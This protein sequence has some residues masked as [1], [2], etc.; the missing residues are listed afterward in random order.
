VSRIRALKDMSE[1]LL[2]AMAS[3][4]GTIVPLGSCWC[5][6]LHKVEAS[7]IKIMQT[8]AFDHF[9]WKLLES[10]GKRLTVWKTFIEN[11]DIGIHGNLAN[12]H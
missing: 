12:K 3:K 7:H 4:K 2:L 6:W 11:F 10:K 5:F 8:V 1:I 9:D